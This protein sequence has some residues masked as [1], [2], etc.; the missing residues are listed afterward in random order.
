MVVWPTGSVLKLINKSD[1]I[2]QSLLVLMVII[3]LTLLAYDCLGLLEVTRWDS[4][5]RLGYLLLRELVRVL[6]NKVIL[7]PWLLSFHWLMEVIKTMVYSGA[8]LADDVSW[9]TVIRTG[10]VHSLVRPRV[11]R[12]S[13]YGDS[14]NNSWTGVIK[15][16]RY[17]RIRLLIQFLYYWT[18][19]SSYILRLEALV[20][21]SGDTLPLDFAITGRSY[22]S[23]RC[24]KSPLG[25]CFNFQSLAWFISPTINR[26]FV[27]L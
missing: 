9:V 18:L 6:I 14:A 3:L 12:R 20:L 21:L 13:S 24:F 15:K 25:L 23:R 2:L 19:F 4:H 8:F 7:G 27:S 10:I 1:H 5:L 17:F 26:A 11:F 22:C 16:S